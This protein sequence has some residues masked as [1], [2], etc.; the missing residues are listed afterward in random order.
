M[1]AS[2]RIYCISHLVCT[3]MHTHTLMYSRPHTWIYI[4]T[5]LT[6]LRWFGSCFLLDLVC[7]TRTRGRVFK[8]MSLS[9]IWH[10]FRVPGNIACSIIGI[11]T[12]GEW[13]NMSFNVKCL[14]NGLTICLKWAGG[15]PW[16]LTAVRACWKTFNLHN[17][18][19]DERLT[20]WKRQQWDRK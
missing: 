5:R 19:Q 8:T 7:K 11:L 9:N 20:S 4:A 15:V 18:W 1:D 6:L 12:Q 13:R 2:S 16:S 10:H 14:P 3:H 17:S